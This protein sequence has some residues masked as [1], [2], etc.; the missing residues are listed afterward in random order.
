ML[1]KLSIHPLFWGVI[2]IGVWTAHFKELLV[3]FTIVFFHELGHAIAATH[4]NWR[5]RKI[6]LLPFG[7]VAELEEHGN[8]PLKEEC[9]VLIAGPAQHFWMF[10]FAYLLHKNGLMSESLYTFFI[11]NNLSILLINLLPIW[12]LDG[13][14]LLFCLY[15]MATSYLRAHQMM[16]F[17]SF[18]CSIL[19]IVAG[20][21]WNK[22]N[23]TM[24]TMLIFLLISLYMEWRQQPYA[25]LRFLL[26][27]YSNKSTVL[28]S[29]TSITA[30]KSD[31]L[32]EVFMKFRRGCKH[33]VIIKEKNK[34]YIL[35][36]NELLYAYFSEKRIRSSIGE[37]LHIGR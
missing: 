5:I 36:E 1:Y 35:D 12:P 32:Y 25:F 10:L 14:K 24:W 18:I 29:I 11:W 21:L 6:Q 20:L 13:G 9:I 15:S 8:K 26:E 31:P 16:L 19:A 30:H 22:T 2:F 17:T 27:R 3:L 23:I 37:I 4:Y 33:S 28:K 34:Q 7:G